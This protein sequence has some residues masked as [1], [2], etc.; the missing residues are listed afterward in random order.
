M[1]LVT[2]SNGQV[3]NEL[4]NLLNEKEALFVDRKN[5]DITNSEQIE[6][7]IITHNIS[8]IIN[9]AAYTAVDKAENEKEKAFLINEAGA[10]NLASLAKKYSIKLVHISTDY[11]FPGNTPTPLTEDSPT[12][13]FTVYGESKLAGEKAILNIRPTAVIIRTSWLYSEFGNNFVKTIVKYA[14]ERSEMK[15]VYDQVGSPTYAKDLA[16]AIIAIIPKMKDGECDLFHYSNEGAVS[17]FDFA[18]AICEIK[19]IKCRLIPIESFEYPTPTP[20][21][22]Y[23]VLSKKKIK[24]TF[25]ISIP[26]WKDSLAKCLENQF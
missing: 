12:A 25:N 18:N 11:V 5:G 24:Q 15:I 14:S 8:T 7:L 26:Y 21:P 4:K 2:G 16:E 6:N 20:R 13:P 3:G 9:C 23:S 19:K 22:K 10:R 17:W 1:I